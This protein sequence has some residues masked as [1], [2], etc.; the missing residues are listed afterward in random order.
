MTTH[1]N[2][3]CVVVSHLSGGAHVKNQT[4]SVQIFVYVFM[5]YFVKLDLRH[6]QKSKT[7]FR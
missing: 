7:S 4:A 5:L 2:K 1:N 3:V 6:C